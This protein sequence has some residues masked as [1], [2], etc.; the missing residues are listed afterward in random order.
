VRLVPRMSGEVANLFVADGERVRPGQPLVALRGAARWEDVTALSGQL[1][2]FERSLSDE[3]AVRAA[4]F[5]P[6][7][8]LGDLHPAYAAFLQSLSDYRASSAGGYDARRVAELERQILD[9]QAVRA[10][11]VAKQRVLG[12]QLG[13]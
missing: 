9:Q 11:A 6:M 10:N 12:D 3:G 5:D 4:A 2:R 7:L 13:P 8:S 1:E